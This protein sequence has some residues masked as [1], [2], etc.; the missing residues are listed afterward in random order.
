[1]DIVIHRISLKPGVKPDEFEAWVTGTDYAGCPNLPS[2]LSF[3]VQRAVAPEDAPWQY[4]EVIAVRSIQ[5]FGRDMKTQTFAHLA[6]GFGRLATVV[7]EISGQRLEPGYISRA[8]ARNSRA[9]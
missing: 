8:I 3:S 1:M 6:D 4:F 2:I 9:S 5:E 7:E